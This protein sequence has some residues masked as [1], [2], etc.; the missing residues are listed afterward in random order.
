M[1]NKKH[2]GRNRSG[3]QP[4]KYIPPKPVTAPVPEPTEEEMGEKYADMGMLRAT[5]HIWKDSS[6]LTFV[7][8]VPV[9]ALYLVYCVLWFGASVLAFFPATLDFAL[10]ARDVLMLGNSFVAAAGIPLLLFILHLGYNMK[11]KKYYFFNTLLYTVPAAFLYVV[12]D[13]LNT[14]VAFMFDTNAGLIIREKAV[15]D[16]VVLAIAIIVTF[17]L[18]CIA[19]FVLS[20][21]RQRDN[22]PFTGVTLQPLKPGRKK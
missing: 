13:M 4:K 6:P 16:L 9:I 20:I 12:L 3:H 21:K 22:P 17:F 2:P 19:Q 10:A 7:T 14:V 18:G 8:Y 5:M 1:A 15:V 11:N